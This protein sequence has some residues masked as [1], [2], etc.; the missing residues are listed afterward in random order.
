MHHPD[1]QRVLAPAFLVDRDEAELESLYARREELH[2][3]EGQVSYVRRLAQGRIEILC[4]E[5]ERRDRGGDPQDL[6]ELICRIPDVMGGGD[7]VPSTRGG[8]ELTPDESFV[9]QIDA[10]VGP[11]AFLAL[12]DYSPSEIDGQ[13]VALEGFERQVSDARRLLH[14]KIDLLQCEIA[15]RFRGAEPVG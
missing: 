5:L 13:V 14:E 4:A 2:R 8:D 6:A 11:S 7:T 15:R 1:V 9:A 12:P 10:V 3:V